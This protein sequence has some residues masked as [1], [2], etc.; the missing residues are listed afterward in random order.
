MRSSKAELPEVIEH[1]RSMARILHLSV[2]SLHRTPPLPYHLYQASLLA[3]VGSSPALPWAA[4]S[5]WPVV[6]SNTN[7][8][9]SFDEWAPSTAGSVGQRSTAGRARAPAASS[10]TSWWLDVRMVLAGAETSVSL[11]IARAPLG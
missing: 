11:C 2:L 10:S 4:A 1:A 9:M 8:L 3:Q 5:P 6:D 7:G